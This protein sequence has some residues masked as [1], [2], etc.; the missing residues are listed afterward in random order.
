M[1]V[2]QA[3]ARHKHVNTTMRYIDVNDVKLQNAV[4]V[5]HLLVFLSNC[6]LA[7]VATISCLQTKSVVV[8][9]DAVPGI[10]FEKSYL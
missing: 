9:R 8:V 3:L 7:G 2:T 1:R 10:L 4:E 5:V 6:L